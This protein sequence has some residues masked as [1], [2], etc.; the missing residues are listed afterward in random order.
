MANY[1]VPADDWTDIETLMGTDYDA[2]DNLALYV[3][4]IPLGLLQVNVNA[5]K[6]TDK[7]MEL[8]SFAKYTIGTG[9]GDTTWVK[10][11]ASPVDIYIYT[12]S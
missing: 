8:P 4:Q 1:T 7:G 12:A 2:T 11:S 9:V 10:A 3:N 6:P 5:T